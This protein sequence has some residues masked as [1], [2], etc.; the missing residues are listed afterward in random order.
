MFRWPFRQRDF[1]YLEA[2][3]LRAVDRFRNASCMAANDF[4]DIRADDYQGKFPLDEILLKGNVLIR[5]DEH[6]EGSGL[7]RAKKLS[8]LDRWRPI[9]FEDG[10][11]FVPG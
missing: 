1:H 5:C 8:V 10:A 7:C 9:H 4:P 6:I 11:N 2:P 3:W